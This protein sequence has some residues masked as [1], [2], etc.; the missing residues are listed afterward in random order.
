[1]FDCFYG[2]VS[3]DSS[4]R[5]DDGAST[6]ERLF[7]WVLGTALIVSNNVHGAEIVKPFAAPAAAP[8]PASNISNLGQVTFALL[9][10]LAAVFAV[11][12]MLRRLKV[13]N[14]KGARHLEVVAELALGAKERAVLV[15]AGKKHVLLGVTATQVSA[16]HVLAADELE[17]D[18]VDTDPS[19]P[20]A[21]SFKALLRQSLGLK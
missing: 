11:A 14:R 9:L 20:A 21:P 10:V 3:A 5:R 19:A 2:I 4:S 16:L 8:V 13:L 12:W 1:M 6:G 18:D 7:G 17:K 15:R